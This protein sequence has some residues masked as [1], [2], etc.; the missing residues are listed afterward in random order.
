MTETKRPLWIWIASIVA[1]VFGLLTIKSGGSVL[2]FD[3]E[4][5]Q[6]AGR[7][8]PFVLWFNFLAG[9]IYVTTGIGLWLSKRWALWLAIALALATLTVFAILGLHIINQ[10]EYETRTLAAM[11]IRSAVWVTIAGMSWFLWPKR[12]GVPAGE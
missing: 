5:R 7:Y 11:T 8:V 6:A 4:A 12:E 1:I 2:F 10:G 3:G 9:F